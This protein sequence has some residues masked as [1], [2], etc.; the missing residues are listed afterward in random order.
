MNNKTDTTIS[1]REKTSLEC[2]IERLE[3]AFS[4]LVISLR[5][6]EEV[7]ENFT[8][9]SVKEK[10]ELGS[11]W[12]VLPQSSDRDLYNRLSDLTFCLESASSHLDAIVNRL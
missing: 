12:G 9:P 2:S 3:E 1:L 7:T 4:K 10:S 11:E 5:N 6:A 8:L